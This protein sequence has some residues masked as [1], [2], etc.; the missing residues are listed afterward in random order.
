MGYDEVHAVAK[1][2]LELGTA[3]RDD[4]MQRLTHLNAAL[5]LEVRLRRMT[6]PPVSGGP[7][8]AGSPAAM[9][10]GMAA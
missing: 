8:P 2:E 6:P 3:C 1:Q 4:F 5:A 7:A 10:V 9:P